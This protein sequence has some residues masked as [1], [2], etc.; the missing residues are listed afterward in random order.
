MKELQTFDSRFEANFLTQL[1]DENGIAYI[2][3][4]DDAGGMFPTN[5][6]FGSVRVFVGE[7]DFARSSALLQE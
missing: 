4:A 6:N 7:D 5:A 1:L 2:I 3:Q